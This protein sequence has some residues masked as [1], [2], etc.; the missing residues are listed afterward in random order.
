M[1]KKKK[2]RPFLSGTFKLWIVAIIFFIIFLH[3]Y[4]ITTYPRIIIVPTEVILGAVLALIAYLWIQELRDRN[5]LQALNKALIAAQK[6]LQQAEIDTIAVLILTEEAKDPYT[7]GHSKRVAQYSAA[8]GKAM[9]FSEEKQSVIER[10]GILHDL[11]KIGI[12]DNILNKPGKLNEEEW[13]IMK[14]HPQRALE[15]L[16]PLKFLPAEKEIVLHHHERYAGG[17]YPDGIKGEDI[18]LGGRIMAV[19]DTFDAMNSARPYRKSLSKEAI[20]S[21]LK[22]VSGDQL[23]SSIVSIFLDL[24]QKNSHFWERG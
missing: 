17:G 16:E 20:L 9:G 14:S 4:V 12:G 13:K 10:A 6:R 11:G 24:L 2:H 21:E 1:H 18:P 22:R 23:D 15:I 7:R 5:R 19:A 3:L 8:M